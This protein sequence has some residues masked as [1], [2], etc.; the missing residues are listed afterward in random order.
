M[1]TVKEAEERANTLRHI[2]DS[3]RR[4]AEISEREAQEAEAT[5]ADALDRALMALET[6]AS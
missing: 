6:P 2:A 1:F 4:S 5:Y 3:F